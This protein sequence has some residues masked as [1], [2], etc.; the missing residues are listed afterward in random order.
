MGLETAKV[1][2]AKGC[3]VYEFSRHENLIQGVNH[4]TADVTDTE[5]V[6]KGVNTIIASEGKIDI[7]INCA[8]FGVA[9][10]I[11]FMEISEV[12]SQFEVNFFGMVNVCKAVLPYMRKA[13]KGRIINISSVA[14]VAPIPF[15]AYYSASKA[16]IDSYSCAL[17]NELKPFN[18][19]VAAIQPGDICT[20]FTQARK[21]ILRG[22][23]EY[24]GQI[25]RSIAKMEQDERN[26]MSPSIAG[27]YI[28]KIALKKK[29]KPIYAI[30]FTYKFLCLLIKLLPV[31][32]TNFILGKMYCK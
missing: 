9:G 8:G 18:I 23:E 17:A 31:R 26:G 19:S 2:W 11:E 5:A 13:G 4:I 25:S 6:V 7:L 16:A 22:D 28:A 15:Q 30:G 29:I 10:A 20:P 1:L 3:I 27:K 14:A 12:K 32:F 21:K 24:E